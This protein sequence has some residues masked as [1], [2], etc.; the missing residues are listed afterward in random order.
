MDDDRSP[1]SAADA[2]RISGRDQDT[3]DSLTN[4]IGVEQT[5]IQ[6]KVNSLGAAWPKANTES[7]SHSADW[8]RQS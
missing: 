7:M 5:A 1:S 2:D 3:V 8:K 6:D 4:S